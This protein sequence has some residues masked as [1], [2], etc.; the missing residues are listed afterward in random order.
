MVMVLIGLAAGLTLPKFAP[1]RERQALRAARGD[2]V[3][4]V[5]AA[6]GAA[7]RRGRVARVLAFPDSHYV[8]AVVDTGPPAA[9]VRFQ[10][11]VSA[12]L[13]TQ[14]AGVRLSLAA[15]GDS[16][17][18]YDGRGF[19]RVPDGRTVVYRLRSPS[20][21]TDSVC[22]TPLGLILPPDCTP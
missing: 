14:Y 13:P 5:E 16:V 21:A 3:S 10:V 18:A 7:L 11:G 19:A 4:V 22:V 2:V 1:I 12:T 9:V 17:L 20:G 6:R 15:A 8:R